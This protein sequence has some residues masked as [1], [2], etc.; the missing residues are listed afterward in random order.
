MTARQGWK[1]TRRSTSLAPD[2]LR[3][4]LKIGRYC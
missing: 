4:A 2:A 3:H 1:P